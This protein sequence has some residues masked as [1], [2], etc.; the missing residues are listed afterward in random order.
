MK[1]FGQFTGRHLEQGERQ[2]PVALGG[3][4]AAGVLFLGNPDA[5]LGHSLFVDI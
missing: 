1:I 3:Q 2:P 5:Y 4:Y